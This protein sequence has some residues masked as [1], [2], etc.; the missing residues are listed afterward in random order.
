MNLFLSTSMAHNVIS[1]RTLLRTL[2]FWKSLSSLYNLG[3][4][5]QKGPKIPQN[6][7]SLNRDL[8]KFL[9]RHGIFS[10][11]PGE[12][13]CPDG[14][15]YVWERGVGSLQ[16]RVTAARSWPLFREEKKY[17]K[18]CSKKP[19]GRNF[20]FRAKS[21]I[22]LATTVFREGKKYLKQCYKKPFGHNFQDWA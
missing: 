11:P 20:D 17:L 7:G 16:G 1:C 12:S 8:L 14:S 2:K 15:E 4:R 21:S 19:P 22:C 18:R 9:N 10:V 6:D 3:S 13:S 5:A